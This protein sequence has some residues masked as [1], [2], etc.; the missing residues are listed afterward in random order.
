MTFIR[1]A[2]WRLLLLPVPLFPAL[3]IGW[4]TIPH[5]R[6]FILGAW[7]ATVFWVCV[8]LVNTLDGGH[9]VRAGF[10]AE[11][12]TADLLKKLRRRGWTVEHNIL[13]EG[14]DVDHALLGPGG[15]IAIETKYTSDEWQIT[16][17]GIEKIG[18]SGRAFPVAWPLACAR[19]AA[20]DLHFILLACPG[21]VRVS[22][23]AVLVL[24]GPRLHEIPGGSME[25]G[26]VLVVLGG[27]AKQW[28]PRLAAHPLAD[29]ELA[30]ARESLRARIEDHVPRAA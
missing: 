11:Q 25:I 13:R 23:R 21:R 18:F 3:L 30:R 6:Q 7:A 4:L 2:W 22:V 5:H 15:A 20:R 27:Q 19:R 10:E 17:R 8:W 24:W 1:R 29:D 12:M 9:G 28:L 26:D 16:E 14:R